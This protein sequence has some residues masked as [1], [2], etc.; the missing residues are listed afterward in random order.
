MTLNKNGKLNNIVDIIY[1][2]SNN[3]FDPSSAAHDCFF[4]LIAVL[5]TTDFNF[6][7]KL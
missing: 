3:Y 6:I 7:I 2:I 5:A 1:T 4:V